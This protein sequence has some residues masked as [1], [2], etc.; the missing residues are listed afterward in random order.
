MGV[1][2]GGAS[3]GNNNLDKL[4][5]FFTRSRG[6]HSGEQVSKDR[7]RCSPRQA[8]HTKTV[9]MVCSSTSYLHLQYNFL[10]LFL[11]FC[12]KIVS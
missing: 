1:A 3:D 10:A 2:D 11:I 12:F 6:W 9:K 5:I 7:S 4:E 8:P